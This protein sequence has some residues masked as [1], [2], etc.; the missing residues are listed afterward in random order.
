[1]VCLHLQQSLHLLSTPNCPFETFQSFHSHPP[2]RFISQLC[3]VS[4]TVSETYAL[5]CN[6]TLS[7]IP[8]HTFG[9][10]RCHKETLI[11]GLTVEF[12]FS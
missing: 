7:H 2:S 5:A 8:T 1:M 11:S 12:K 6:L 4:F 3:K 10:M 9:S